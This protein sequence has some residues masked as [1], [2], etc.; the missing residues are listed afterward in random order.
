MKLESHEFIRYF[1]P[2]QAAQISQIAII[3]KFNPQEIIFEEGDQSDALFLVLE[4]EVQVSKKSG[5]GNNY[6]VITSVESDGYFGELGII[7]KQPRSGRVVASKETIVATISYD[8]IID[9]LANTKGDVV[10]KIL[11]ILPQRLRNVTTEYVNQLAYKEKMTLIGEMLNTIIHDFRSPFT[12]IQLSS[13]MLKELHPDPESQEWCD[14]ISMQV[15]RMLNMAEEVLAFSQGN[16][17]LYCQPIDI[18]NLL[19]NFAKLNQ[20]YV[21]S[22]FVKLIVSVEEGLIINADENKI[23]R[24]LQNLLANALEAINQYEGK[25]EIKAKRKER[26]VEIIFSDNGSGI[27][28]EIQDNLFEAFVSYGKQGGI[29]LGTAIVKTIIDAHSGEI[30]FESTPGKGTTFYLRFPLATT[31]INN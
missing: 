20:V 15:Q 14:L 27:P 9:I 8:S 30:F 29:G 4:G 19:Q 18:A 21:D 13:S 22:A 7:D 10:L 1:E 23:N 24:A 16:T 2:E 26:W 3:K 25:I 11:S 5:G 12:G 31:I 6:V 28:K 17:K